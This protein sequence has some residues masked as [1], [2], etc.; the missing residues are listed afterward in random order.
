M[1]INYKIETDEGHVVAG[2]KQINSL[3]MKELV[4]ILNIKISKPKKKDPKQWDLLDMIEDI[5]NK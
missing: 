3:Q 1:V 4:K 2:S 5:K